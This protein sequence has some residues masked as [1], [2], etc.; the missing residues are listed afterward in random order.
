MPV[1]H[2]VSCPSQGHVQLQT[3]TIGA[4]THSITAGCILWQKDQSVVVVYAKFG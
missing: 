2:L 3:S 4:V 1:G